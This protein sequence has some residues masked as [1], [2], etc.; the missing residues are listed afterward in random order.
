[1]QGEMD[2]GGPLD[3]GPD[4]V[5]RRHA[6]TS[7]SSSFRHQRESSQGTP[8]VFGC[9]RMSMLPCLAEKARVHTTS[10]VFRHVLLT[11]FFRQTP[12][13]HTGSWG[14]AAVAVHP[15][16]VHTALAS[17]FFKSQSLAWTSRVPGLHRVITGTA[18]NQPQA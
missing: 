1:M 2:E 12:G 8:C 18:F 13:G 9:I 10:L 7:F 14:D 11:S 17:G 4:R 16:V 3:W 6:A 15:G 5:A